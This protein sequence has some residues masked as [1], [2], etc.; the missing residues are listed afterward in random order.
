MRAM[1]MLSTCCRA[2]NDVIREGGP[3]SFHVPVTHEDVCR[4]VEM[5]IHIYSVSIHRAKLL[6]F[7]NKSVEFPLGIPIP[8]RGP[9]AVDFPIQAFQYILANPVAIPRSFR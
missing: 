9:D 5:Q 8:V 3:R 1:N 7:L 4:I 6:N 2:P